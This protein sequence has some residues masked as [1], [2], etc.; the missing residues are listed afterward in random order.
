MSTATDYLNSLLGVSQ[1]A[2]DGK[3]QI[4]KLDS[5]FVN[6]G[7]AES[8]L[9]QLMS[10]ATP[11][12]NKTTT[13]TTAAASTGQADLSDVTSVAAMAKAN[14]WADPTAFS[15]DMLDQNPF[16]PGSIQKGGSGADGGIENPTYVKFKDPASR[17]ITDTGRNL[18][19]VE[20]LQ[21][22]KVFKDTETSTDQDFTVTPGGYKVLAGA[23]P[24]TKQHT[25]LYYQYDKDGKFLGANFDQEESFAQGIAPL[26]QMATMAMG[27]GGGTAALG[28]S[29]NSALGLGLGTTGQAVL[30]GTLVGGGG[31]ALT[32]QNIVKGAATGGASAAINA[33]NP[34]GMASITNPTLAGAANGALSGGASA[35]INGGDVGTSM[36]TGAAQGALTSSTKKPVAATPSTPTLPPNYWLPLA[37]NRA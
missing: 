23:V 1:E 3:P 29:A 14:G 37:N 2:K 19:R 27:L 26:V 7:G 13:A 35:L 16:G 25:A 34:A 36:I 20:V 30:G 8:Y 9:D 10:G 22:K 24:G 28:A 21:D 4:T 18:N 15:V 11:E 17:G 6:Q 12:A 32:G 5:L 31:A 33:I